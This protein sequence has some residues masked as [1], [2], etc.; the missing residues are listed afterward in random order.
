MLN[1]W[2]GE[3]AVKILLNFKNFKFEMFLTGSNMATVH[4]LRVTGCTQ[5]PCQFVIGTTVVIE[6]DATARKLTK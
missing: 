4:R 6:V 3:I 2:D 1:C 5:T